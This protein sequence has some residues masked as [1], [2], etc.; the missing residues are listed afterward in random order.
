MHAG[1]L[2]FEHR[3]HL[4]DGRRFAR[5]WGSNSRSSWVPPSPS[6]NVERAGLV[7]ITALQTGAGC[8]QIR[9]F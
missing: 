4:R 8:A 6:C 9:C 7:R 5:S 1:E 2:A 3:L